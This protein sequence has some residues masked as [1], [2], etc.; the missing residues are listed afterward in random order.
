MVSVFGVD[1]QC[2]LVMHKSEF[3]NALAIFVF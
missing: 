1:V 3:G 2:V